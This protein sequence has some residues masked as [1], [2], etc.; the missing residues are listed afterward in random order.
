MLDQNPHSKQIRLFRSEW[1]ERLTIISPVGFAVIWAILLPSIAWVG[2]GSTTAL[3]AIGL[4][5]GGLVFWSLF[6]YAMHRYLFHWGSDVPVVRQFVFLMH[7]NHHSAPNDAL[8]N[9]MPPIVSIP[10]AS[11][12]WGL[13]ILLFGSVG[14][15]VFFGFIVGYVLYDLTHFACHQWAMRGRF[16]LMLKRHHMRHHHIDQNGN[17]AITALF[18]DRVF[19][20][21]ITSLKPRT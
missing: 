3:N 1:L 4:F 20:S 15:W 7:G 12:I 6:E 21:L 11:S 13:C 18:W 10:I 5:A 9:L 19:G 17:Y 16:A 8:R 2:W 14:T